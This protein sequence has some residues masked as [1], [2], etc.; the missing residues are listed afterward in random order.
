MT[1]VTR[2]QIRQ[3]RIHSHH[4]DRWYGIEEAASAAGA[5]GFQNS[6]PGA[7]ETSLCNRI[8]DVT[9]KE[10]EALLERE[11]ALLQAWSFRGAPVV[12][13]K[14]ES[15]V[16]L[17]ALVPEGEEPWIYTRGIDLALDFLQMPFEELLFLLGQVIGKLDGKVVKSKAALDQLL[18]QWMLPLIP[19]DKRNLWTSPS[20][21]GSSGSQTVGGAAVSFLL[22]PCAFMGLVVFGK[23]EGISPTFTSYKGW[24]G[25]F[26]EGKEYCR[27]KLAHKYLHCFGPGTVREFGAWLGCSPAQAGRIWQQAANELE[28]VAVGGKE[29]YILR[30]DRELLLSPVHP[31]R[32]LHLLGGHDPYLGLQDRELILEEKN[33]QRQIWQTVSNPGAVL[34]QGVIAG[35]WKSKKKGKELAV[36]V[37]LW[38]EQD[39]PKR[40]IQE[41]AEK[42]AFFHQLKPGGIIFK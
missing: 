38:N 30:E 4:L 15:N 42:I 37:T 26:P 35:M 3:F 28:P 31:E 19:E 9:H 25:E 22:R 32:S 21:Y 14:D 16:F 10:A 12:F 34:W 27:R 33:L 8:S 6:P 1:E 24:A 39:I 23:R 13:P 2:E 20:M 41:Q 18:A 11:K 7:W 5:C 40:E 29:R 36:E 17:S